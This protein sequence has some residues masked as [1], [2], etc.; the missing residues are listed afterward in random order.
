MTVFERLEKNNFP[1]PTVETFVSRTETA[2]NSKIRNFRIDNI[3]NFRVEIL[4][5]Q[6]T[7]LHTIACSTHLFVW[8]AAKTGR[9]RWIRRVQ[10]IGKRWER[11]MR[12]FAAVEALQQRSAILHTT[13]QL[14]RRLAEAVGDGI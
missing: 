1:C 2:D 6:C 11:R 7:Q 10:R 3:Q 4:E 5:Y 12:K 9:V 14:L 8:A 13:P